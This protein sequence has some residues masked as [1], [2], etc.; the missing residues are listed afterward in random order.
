MTSRTTWLF[1]AGTIAPLLYLY[2]S[3]LGW[4][5]HNARFYPDTT[6]EMVILGTQLLRLLVVM[7]VPRFRRAGFLA[8]LDVFTVELVAFIALILLSIH[9]GG[10]YYLSI[11]GQIVWAWPPA[12]LISFLPF[13]MFRLGSMMRREPALSITIPSVA[14]VL[15][16]L[17]FMASATTTYTQF[18]GL[19]GVSALLLKAIFGSIITPSIPFYVT[20][21]GIAL[22]LVLIVYAVSQ[23]SAAPPGRTGLLFFA[24]AGA[25]AAVGWKLAAAPFTSS[26]LLVF[27]LPALLLVGLIWGIT[28]AR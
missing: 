6:V 22:Y 21:A 5:H 10:A 14:A 28:R 27:G 26:E 4:F 19:M 15:V 3:F 11:A 16:A 2:L 17:T 12:F 9:Y 25:A 20:E 24:V 1:I 23:G 18:D 7:A 8:V 13:V